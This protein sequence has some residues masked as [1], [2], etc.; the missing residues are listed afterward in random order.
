MWSSGCCGTD[1]AEPTDDMRMLMNSQEAAEGHAHADEGADEGGSVPPASSSSQP[2]PAKP[3]VQVD[4]CDDMMASVLGH[5][6]EVGE[7]DNMS[8]LAWP[9]Q[10]QHHSHYMCVRILLHMSYISSY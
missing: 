3:H 9:S 7:L 4:D 2:I 10:V 5:M 6:S 8:S 1:E